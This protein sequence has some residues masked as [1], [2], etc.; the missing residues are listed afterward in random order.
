MDLEKIGYTS[1]EQAAYDAY[2]AA[3]SSDAESGKDPACFALGRVARVDRGECDVMT[4]NGVQRVASDQLRAQRDQAPAT[5]DWVVVDHCNDAGSVIAHILPRRSAMV[6][7]DPSERVEEQVLVANADIVGIVQPLDQDLNLARIER[8]LVLALDSGARP[9]VILTKADLRPREVGVEAQTTVETITEASVLLTSAENG[10]GVDEVR[11]SLGDA[12]MVLVGPSGSGKSTLTN[13]LVGK[14]LQAT[15]QVRESDAK[16]RHT[17]VSRD[18][19]P[20]DGGGVLIDTPGIRAVGIWEAD[21]ALDRV[22]A[23]VAEV[24]TGCRFADCTHR[25]E[26]GCA[27]RAAVDSGA[28]TRERVERYQILWNEITDQ[29]DAAVQRE[30]TSRRRRPI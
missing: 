4:E 2:V 8:F 25:Q 30:W 16:G 26:P 17:T 12:T 14:D 11:S 1:Q 29:A 15:A 7:R 23:D 9:L 13:R 21:A 24:A 6:R 28:L 10:E 20:L 22:F 19:I 5:G 18:L 27:V 3:A